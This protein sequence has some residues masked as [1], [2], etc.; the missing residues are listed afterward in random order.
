MDVVLDQLYDRQTLPDTISSLRTLGLHAVLLCLPTDGVA[1]YLQ[2]SKS[3]DFAAPVTMTVANSLESVARAM[4]NGGEDRSEDMSN[5]RWDAMW[6]LTAVCGPPSYW[7]NDEETAKVSAAEMDHAMERFFRWKYRR[8][9]NND[10]LAAG[11]MLQV[12]L[13]GYQKNMAGTPSHMAEYLHNARVQ[14][15]YG[16]LDMSGDVFSSN[17]CFLM[18]YQQEQTLVHDPTLVFPTK[19][20]VYPAP[21]W[22]T[23][24]CTIPANMRNNTGFDSAGNCGACPEYQPAYWDKDSQRRLCRSCPEGRNYLRIDAETAICSVTCSEAQVPNLAGDGCLDCEVGKY[25]D[26][27]GTVL[28]CIDCPW[29]SIRPQGQLTCT[30]CSKG[31]YQSFDLKGLRCTSCERGKATASNGSFDCLSCEVGFYA[32]Q[33]GMSDCLR[34]ASGHVSSVDRDSCSVCPPGK[35]ASAGRPTCTQCPAGSFQR[36]AGQTS[37]T[38]DSAC[39]RSPVPGMAEPYNRN[40]YYKLDRERVEQCAIPDACLEKYTC[41]EGSMSRQCFACK[42]GYFADPRCKKCPAQLVNI[43]MHALVFLFA[44]MCYQLIVSTAMKASNKP[45]SVITSMIKLVVNHLIQMS[46]LIRAIETFVIAKGKSGFLVDS[47]GKSALET[48]SMFSQDGLLNTEAIWLSTSCLLQLPLSDQERQ[49]LQQLES[50]PHDDYYSSHLA[51]ARES[52]QRYQ[53]KVELNTLMFWNGA[54]IVLMFAALMMNYVKMHRYMTKK[55]ELWL[56]A[57]RFLTQLSF[58]KWRDVKDMHE[59]KT[60]KQLVKVYNTQLGGMYWPISHLRA[61]IRQRTLCGIR[62]RRIGLRQF[63]NESMPMIMIFLWLLSF[64]IARKCLRP[65]RCISLGSSGE[66]SLVMLAAGALECSSGQGLIWVSGFVAMFWVAVLPTVLFF[67]FSRAFRRDKSVSKRHAIFGDSYSSKFW[68]WESIAFVRKFL[69]LVLEVIELRPPQKF[70][71]FANLGFAC[72][73]LH[74]SAQPYD[75]FKKDLQSLERDQLVIFTGISLLFISTSPDWFGALF[76]L[77]SVVNV[78]YIFRVLCLIAYHSALDYA[79]SLDEEVVKERADGTI[80][81]I[82]TMLLKW[83]AHMREQQPY[84]SYDLL[85]GFVTVVGSRGDQAVSPYVPRGRDF[86]GDRQSGRARLT[87][88]PLVPDLHGLGIVREAFTL[89]ADLRQAKCSVLGPAPAQEIDRTILTAALVAADPVKLTEKPEWLDDD[90]VDD[91][92][93]HE[94]DSTMTQE[95]IDLARSCRAVQ[96]DLQANQYETIQQLGEWHRCRVILERAVQENRSII[97]KDFEKEIQVEPEVTVVPFNDEDEFDH[98]V[99]DGVA[100]KDKADFEKRVHLQVARMFS[101]GSFRRGVVLQD[102]EKGLHAAQQLNRNE[103]KLMMDIFERMWLQEKILE[104]KQLRSLCGVVE[105]RA[106]NTEDEMLALTSGEDEVPCDYGKV[107]LMWCILSMCLCN[108]NRV[109]VT[110]A[111]QLGGARRKRHSR[112][113]NVLPGSELPGRETTFS[114]IVA[115]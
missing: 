29:G 61:W 89:A 56:Q 114:V 13:H 19:P 67:T 45:N 92:E 102:L 66:H 8:K 4:L 5:P 64:P 94:P 39:C 26:R 7:M 106:M 96:R 69:L 90:N 11:A 81:N 22:E 70:F 34:C 77:G 55:H 36:N 97:A 110:L 84:V 50:A 58:F 101:P 42:P 41:E 86:S 53:W 62:F 49:H 31:T 74:L 54:P 91:D 59:A 82:Q 115:I 112:R 85:H 16:E 100:T 111:S 93:D 83:L 108:R 76:F 17:G 46:V 21:S 33:E 23:R 52:F 48:M 6:L 109:P 12:L 10:A 104:D 32:S 37:C 75:R 78:L 30:Q 9:R 107:P 113:N 65:L 80:K 28:R 44:L 25:A 71:L 105:E 40:G 98:E 99:A 47:F 51:D 15:L 35:Y 18:Q 2:V 14:T 3:L 60:V 103:A 20:F 79:A 38:Q 24:F 72:L 57:P 88:A 43:I 87:E 73:G 68:W 1:H 95:D 27:N 63:C